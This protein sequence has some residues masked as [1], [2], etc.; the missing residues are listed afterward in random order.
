MHLIP[1][2][3]IVVHLKKYLGEIM[4][5]V[6]LVEYEWSTDKYTAENSNNKNVIFYCK[7]PLTP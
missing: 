1:A 5:I 3:G 2:T 4:C 6:D 7:C